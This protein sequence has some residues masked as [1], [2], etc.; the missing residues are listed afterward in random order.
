MQ[1]SDMTGPDCHYRLYHELADW[2]PVISPPQRYTDEAAFLG[3]V[4]AFSTDPAKDVLDL[5][6]GGGHMAF[7]LKRRFALTLVDISA[8]MLAVSRRLNPDC[9]HVR[10]DMRTIRLGREFDAVLVHDAIDYITTT[11]GLRLVIETAFAHTRPGGVALFVPDHVKDDFEPGTAGGGNGA[12]AS[13]LVTTYDPDAAD[14]WIAADYE[15]TLRQPDGQTEVVR[16]THRLGA[17]AR[18]TWLAEL[19]RAGFVVPGQRAD[20]GRYYA[21]HEYFGRMKPG[22][23]AQL[24]IGRRRT[25]PRSTQPPPEP[26]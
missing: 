14:D 2:W 11:G 19:E 16:E 1:G 9:E 5:G 21:P 20:R 10:G 25:S 26:G 22:R 12:Q 7:H 3:D 8:Q 23:P 4:I 6:S 13:F 15:F 17:F 24:F 18:A